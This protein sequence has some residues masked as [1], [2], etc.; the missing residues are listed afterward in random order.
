MLLFKASLFVTHGKR[1]YYKNNKLK[2][3][4]VTWNDGLELPDGLYPESEI[5][6]YIMYVIR[7]TKL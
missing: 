2:I 1:N 5:Q 6:Y 3:K 7:N 4:V